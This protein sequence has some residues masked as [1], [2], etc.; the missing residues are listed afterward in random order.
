MS[1]QV[2][3]GKSQSQ[4][5]QLERLRNDLA[6]NA[7]F[8]R[9][10]GRMGAGLVEHARRIARSGSARKAVA[11]WDADNA[12]MRIMMNLLR[13]YGADGF[14]IAIDELCMALGDPH[15]RVTG[16]TVPLEQTTPFTI[17]VID[18]E[19]TFA[20]MR[21]VI[22]HKTRYGVDG[23]GLYDAPYSLWNRNTRE[24]KSGIDPV[25]RRIAERTEKP[26]WS[27]ENNSWFWMKCWHAL[28]IGFSK[29]L[30]IRGEP[31]GHQ[32][33]N[34]VPAGER[35]LNIVMRE[36]QHA[37]RAREIPPDAWTQARITSALHAVP[38]M[39]CAFGVPMRQS[40]VL[41]L[42]PRE[43]QGTLLATWQFNLP[44]VYDLG[45]P[46]K[47]YTVGFHPEAEHRRWQKE[48]P[49]FASLG[50]SRGMGAIILPNAEPGVDAWYPEEE[51]HLLLSKLLED[52]LDKS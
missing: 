39:V 16:E 4:E 14:E 40:E 46:E 44:A 15:Y 28:L 24:L 6:G 2:P 5:A 18:P 13:K 17:V 42:Y 34:L 23:E 52:D 20:F 41:A 26:V 51:P 30:D 19:E 3:E 38:T 10:R 35:Y 43:A 1:N 45:N 48:R 21:W 11:E 12:A 8:R 50:V 32:A 47:R 31:G 49:T 36:I 7:A 27:P 37:H 33:D 9:V 29:R 22:G 25:M